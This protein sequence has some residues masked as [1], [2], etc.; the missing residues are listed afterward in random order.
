[1]SPQLLT[2]CLQQRGLQPSLLPARHSTCFPPLSSI[3][4]VSPFHHASPHAL[5][6]LSSPL[7]LSP[8]LLSLFPHTLPFSF[9]RPSPLY[10][11]LPRP[12]ILS[13]L[14]V[15]KQP[16]SWSQSSLPTS[17]VSIRWDGQGGSPYLL[18]P[19]AVGVGL[20]LHRRAALNDKQR[21]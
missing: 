17:R 14:P 4:H 16:H 12:L 11:S 2:Q 18:R 1:M 8:A 9:L 5:S 6:L 21:Y 3:S 15:W 20:G 19:A 7:S 13:L 10:P